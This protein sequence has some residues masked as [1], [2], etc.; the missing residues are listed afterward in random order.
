[1]EST[2]GFN[3]YEGSTS[4]HSK[5]PRI[6]VRRGGLMVLTPATVD[7]LGDSVTHVQLGF[8]PKTKAVAIRHAADD[9]KGRYR[10]RRQKNSPMLIVGGKKFFAHHDLPVNKAA[11]FDAEQIGDGLVGFSL[12]AGYN[13]GNGNGSRNSGGDN[14]NKK[15][16]E[17]S[18]KK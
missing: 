11:T 6:T 1:M 3:F 8:N 4:A 14:G 12:A 16:P 17:K 7:L 5:E 2:H 15:D 9:A 13:G 18:A 10:I